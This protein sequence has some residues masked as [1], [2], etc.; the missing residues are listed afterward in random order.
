MLHGYGFI[1]VFVAALPLRAAER[2]HDFH[3]ELHGFIEQLEH[4]LTW[5]ILLLLGV[6]I[7]A[8]LLAP[9]TWPARRSAR[10]WCWW[11]VP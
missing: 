4:I 2:S 1:A 10:C 6:A 9:L 7:T 3:E 5:G 8:G 11:S